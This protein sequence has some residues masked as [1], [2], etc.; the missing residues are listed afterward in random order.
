MKTNQLKGIKI[1]LTAYELEQKEHRGISAVSKSLIKLLNKYGA[2]IYLITGFYAK[3]IGIENRIFKRN[4][5]DKEI[6]ISDIFDDLN[7]GANYRDE[8]KTSNRY[9]IKLIFQLLIQIILLISNNFKFRYQIFDIN[10]NHKLTNIFNVRMEYLNY[11]KGFISVKH[12]FHICRL[13]SMRILIKTPKLKIENM[14]LIISLSPLSIKSYPKGRKKL[15]QLVH[16]LI[17]IQVTDHPENPN[18]FYNRIKDAHQHNQCIYVSEESRR[19]AR[20]TIEINKFNNKDYEILNPLPS[21]NLNQL[22]KAINLKNIRNIDRPFI[23]FNSSIV[24][25]KRVENAL[26][27][28][29]NSNLSEQNILFCLAGKLHDS[30]YCDHIKNICCNK[31]NILLLDYVSDLEKAW[32]FLNSSLLLSTSSIEGFGIPVLDA[33]SID[34]PTLATNIPSHNEI[35]K[36]R[37]NGNTVLINQNDDETW[38]KHLNNINIFQINDMDKKLNRIESFNK[39]INH[40][41]GISISKI[42]KYL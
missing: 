33:M 24:E 29:I 27:L 39:F 20:E 2:D 32:L 38:L 40:I 30:R 12:I 41:E 5:L 37:Q 1:A 8:F 18:I 23:L 17:P 21:L 15:I 9:K 7:K 25:R 11:I 4:K 13:R 34:L 22:K 6:A 36:L 16:D 35:A 10:E 31:K 14:D 26:Q 42:E 19:L 3:R 28:Y